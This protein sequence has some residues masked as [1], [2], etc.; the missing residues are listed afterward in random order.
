GK[1]DGYETAQLYIRDVKAKL[2]ARPLKEL[3][4]FEKVFLKSGEKKTVTFEITEEMLKFY[5]KD[6]NFVAENGEFIIYVGA[7]SMDNRNSV[8]FE[9]I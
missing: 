8:K 7:H 6:C 3:K 4:G 2:V 9:L 5:D 1:R